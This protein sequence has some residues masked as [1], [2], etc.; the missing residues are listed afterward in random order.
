MAEGLGHIIKNA[1]QI[2]QLKGISLHDSPAITHQKFVDD[3]MLF[4]HPSV[5]EALMFKSLLD[6]YSEASRAIINNKIPNFLFSHSPHYSILY[7][8]HSWIL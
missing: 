6:E 8:T 1:L 2:Q 4:G 7:N 3:N 5:Q